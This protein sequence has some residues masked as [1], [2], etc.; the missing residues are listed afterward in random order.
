M[1]KQDAL[2]F[3]TICVKLGA[4]YALNKRSKESTEEELLKNINTFI[5]KH[6]SLFQKIFG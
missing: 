1:K 3:A 4:E 6:D 2:D 5:K